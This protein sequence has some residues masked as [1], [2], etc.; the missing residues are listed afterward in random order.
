MP[1]SGSS[2]DGPECEDSASGGIP[3][4][5][6]LSPYPGGVF[7][8]SDG[9]NWSLGGQSPGN[10]ITTSR[11]QVVEAVPGSRVFVPSQDDP[12]AGLCG[13]L[14]K[15]RSVCS[16]QNNLCT[17]NG[18]DASDVFNQTVQAYADSRGAM[19]DE[20]Y[21]EAAKRFA[22]GMD[23]LSGAESGGAKVF[24]VPWL[25]NQT[26]AHGII[27][28]ASYFKNPKERPQ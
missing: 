23:A 28:A 1:P 20:Y 6:S 5:G 19:S 2:G 18:T 22:D 7:G 4:I 3:S 15:M 13:V 8:S 24:D 26:L 16:D 12:T 27:G 25:G 9:H 11:S 14:G 21:S 17:V 10:N